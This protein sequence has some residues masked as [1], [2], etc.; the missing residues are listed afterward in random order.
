M[1]KYFLSLLVAG[2]CFFFEKAAGQGSVGIGTAAPDLS[3]MLDIS[4]TTKGLLIPRMSSTQRTAIL[5]PAPGLMVF[6]T[7]TE[8]VWTFTTS[9]G[10]TEQ[11]GLTPTTA[12]RMLYATAT[13]GWFP[14]SFLKNHQDTAVSIGNNGLAPMAPFHVE[15]KMHIGR[16]LWTSAANDRYIGFGDL[17][18]AGL[19]Y[20]Y[21]GEVGSDD[22]LFFKASS[23]QFANGRMGINTVPDASA[24]LNINGQ[25]RITDGTEALGKVLTGTGSGYTN[26]QY[27]AAYNTGCAVYTPVGSTSINNNAD[28]RVPFA[29]ELYDDGNNFDNVTNNAY[30]AP[31]A[32]LY[33][34]DISLAWNLTGVASSYKI[35]ML[36]GVFGTANEMASWYDVA[37]GTSGLLTTQLST[38]LKLTAGQNVT[39][40]AYQN[41]GSTQG[42]NGG[43][44]SFRAYRVY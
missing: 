10:W 42:L 3:A 28:T 8:T 18:G 11:K 43:Y 19:P 37:A 29:N 33:H 27:P 20:V 41:S 6:D 9:T 23:F 39:V 4:S 40:F 36:L 17:D 7:N 35:R 31:A 26:F 16:S 13:G 21:L 15:K 30:V 2:S 24:I 44:T 32:G 1:K 25:L 5:A 14:G 38:N 12:D 34:F 22:R